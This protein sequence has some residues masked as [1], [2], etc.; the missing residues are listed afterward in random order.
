MLAEMANSFYKTSQLGCPVKADVFKRRHRADDHGD[1]QFSVLDEW[2]CD[3]TT[4]GGPAWYINHSC[5]PNCFSK[6]VR[7][8][9]DFHIGTC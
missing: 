6:M 4:A 8:G 2:V 9:R 3:A 1:Y 7:V 5:D